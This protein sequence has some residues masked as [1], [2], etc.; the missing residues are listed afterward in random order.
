MIFFSFSEETS[1]LQSDLNIKNQVFTIGMEKQM[2]TKEEL[3]Y[4][5]KSYKQKD[6][7]WQ[8][9]EKRIN[10][11]KEAIIIRASLMGLSVKQTN[12]GEQ[13]FNLLKKEYQDKKVFEL[14]KEFNR[15]PNAIRRILS[16]K[17]VKKKI[18]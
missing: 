2:W 17:G 14:G 16:I 9:L 10:H 12:W 3:E 11:T 13:E 8:D 4:L 6:T 5:K 15:T 1:P 7:D 18:R